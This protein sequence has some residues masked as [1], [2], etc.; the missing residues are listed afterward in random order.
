MAARGWC[1]EPP[2]PGGWRLHPQLLRWGSACMVNAASRTHCPPP[3]GAPGNRRAC[4]RAGGSRVCA[5]D[6]RFRVVPWGFSYQSF[7]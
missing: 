4:G 5:S 1:R 7:T 2:G 6:L 3:G